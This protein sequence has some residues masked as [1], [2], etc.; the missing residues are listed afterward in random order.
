[1]RYEQSKTTLSPFPYSRILVNN[2]KEVIQ[3]NFSH[4]VSV[5]VLCYKRENFIVSA[6]RSII[7]SNVSNKDIE[8]IVV[9]AFNNPVIEKKLTELNSKVIHVDSSLVGARFSEALRICTSDIVFLLDDDD[10]FF[11]GKIES[12]LNVYSKFSNV[13][14]II[15]G[16]KTIDAVGK[17]KQSVIRKKSRYLRSVQEENLFISGSNEPYD[18]VYAM[19]GLDMGFNS[20]RVSF[21]RLSVIPYLDY[22]SK[23]EISL[24]AGLFFIAFYFLKGILDM[25]K[26][27]TGYR[28]HSENISTRPSE[29]TPDIE[30]LQQVLRYAMITEFFY[31]LSRE[32][33]VDKVNDKRFEEYC[34]STEKTVSLYVSLI[35]HD[36]FNI[37][38]R[39]LIDQIVHS[40]RCRHLRLFYRANILSVMITLAGLISSKIVTKITLILGV[41]PNLA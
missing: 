5:I 6:V 1:M 31:R 4:S 8:I 14:Y 35:H 38:T 19:K 11:P 27:L 3:S 21:R 25:K 36:P 17:N 2:D 30:V 22:L 37:V 32:A 10:V 12:H 13:N 9:K 16:Y 20:S 39:K 15:N 23:L 41:I 33:L 7:E 18:I 29:K 40:L 28:I 26:E 24:D 34:L